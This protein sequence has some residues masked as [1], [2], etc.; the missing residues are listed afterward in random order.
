M[1]GLSLKLVI[2]VIL[3]LVVLAIG[4]TMMFGSTDSFSEGASCVSE[5]GRCVDNDRCGGEEIEDTQCSG[6]TICCPIQ[7][8]SVV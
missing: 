1:S 4:T 6:S 3:G 2:G 8:V 5:G 7:D